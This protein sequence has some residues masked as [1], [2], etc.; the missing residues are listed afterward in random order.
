MLRLSCFLFLATALPA[1][2]QS[3]LFG[4]PVD[5]DLDQTCYIQNLVDH[6]PGPGTADFRCGAQGYDGHKGT[7]IALPDLRAQAA[8]VSV[9]A[10]APGTVRAVR[11]DMPDILQGQPGAP[12]TTGREC[13]NGVVIRHGGGWESQYCHMALG[14]IT[15]QPGDR[16][17]MGQPLG[18]IGLSGQSEFPHLHFELRRDGARVDP[19]DPDGE[20]SCTLD[21]ANT[22]WLTPENPAA[23]GLISVGFSTGVP[24]YSAV[25][26]GTADRSLTTDAPI[27]LWGYAFATRPGDILQIVIDGPDGRVHLHEET[28]ERA[29]AQMF[30]ASGRRAPAGGW[31]S[32]SYIGTVT[33]L[34]GAQVL[35][36][37]TVQADLP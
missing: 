21:P 31:A 35:G 2:A 28:L 1:A 16:V 26:A 24:D 15:V 20:E 22:L 36:Q 11:D 34:R 12:D 10:A 3:P 30:R 8:G 14:S 37:M 23:G 6:D 9:L 27:V 7:D 29:Q 18:R 5:C 33:H 32:G 17:A 13:G 25:K 19:F 4:W